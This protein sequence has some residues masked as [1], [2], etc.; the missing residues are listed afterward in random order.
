M[1]IVPP[2]TNGW[3]AA[4]ISWRGARDAEQA[5]KPAATVITTRMTPPD[6][7]RMGEMASGLIYLIGL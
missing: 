4:L 2:E 3:S 6:V 7:I 5:D 1:S